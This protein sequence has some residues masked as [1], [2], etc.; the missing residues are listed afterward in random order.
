MSRVK[1]VAGSSFAGVEV[2][3]EVVLKVVAV[4]SLIIRM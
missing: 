2:I 1:E 3:Q 4:P